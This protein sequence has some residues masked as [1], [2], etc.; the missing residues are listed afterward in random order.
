M[1]DLELPKKGVHHKKRVKKV[2]SNVNYTAILIYLFSFCSSTIVATLETQP[3]IALHNPV[4]ISSSHNQLD[5]E[6]LY[7]QGFLLE[8]E[9]QAIFASRFPV[10]GMVDLQEGSLVLQQDLI[11]RNGTNLQIKQ[12]NSFADIRRFE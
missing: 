8:K 3:P 10:S 7:K 2:M 5:V 1:P 6:T 11:F 12:I 9:V 4:S